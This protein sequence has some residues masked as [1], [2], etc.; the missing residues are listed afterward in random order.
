MPKIRN[1]L[2]FVAIAAALVLVYIF[3]VKPSLDSQNQAGLVSS[4]STNS[5]GVATTTTTTGTDSS[6]T[7]DFLSLLLNINTIK[8]D[9]G[10]FDDPAFN[11][12]HDS[13]I[14][15]IPDVTQGRT[16]PFAQFGSDS[17]S[18]TSVDNTIVI[19]AVPPTTTSKNTP[20]KTPVT[21]K[22]T[23]TTTKTTTTPSTQSTTSTGTSGSVVTP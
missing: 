17:V 12:L 21:A 3:F 2:I 5:S 14:T 19:P 15:L 10:I 7:G 11:S 8:L 1:I 20:T 6:V 16:N 13:T 23:T 22:K 18:T 9:D 4:T